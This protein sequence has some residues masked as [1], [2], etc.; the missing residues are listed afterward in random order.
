MVR[1]G[2]VLEVGQLMGPVSGLHKVE[3]VENDSKRSKSQ[4]KVSGMDES[5]T[6][7]IHVNF[8]S[9]AIYWSKH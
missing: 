4:L 5:I 7:K 2:S 1:P 9:T 8:I 3:E 6:H